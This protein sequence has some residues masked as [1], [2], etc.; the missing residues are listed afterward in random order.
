MYTKLQINKMDLLI[1]LYIAC[2]AISELMGS[3]TFPIAIPGLP[4]L[5]A[6]VA[7]FVLPL[8]FT[9]ND[10]ITEVYG[11]DRTRSIVRSGLLTIVLLLGFSLLATHLP[12]SIRFAPTEPAYKAI[13]GLSARISAASL[14]AF[15]VAEY[16]D[17]LIFVKVR[18]RFGKKALWFRNNVSNIVSQFCDTVIFMTLAFYSFGKPVIPNIIFLVSLIVP[19]FVLKCVMSAL[20]TPVVY[21]G[22]KWLGE[23]N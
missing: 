9:I 11:K 13:F 7:M 18:E 1:S 6:S 16:L 19:Y 8:V 2:I 10:V 22:V 4:T 23:E 14:I 5:N 3:K 12:A 21:L 15:A 17:V 20:V